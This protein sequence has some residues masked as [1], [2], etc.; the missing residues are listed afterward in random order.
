MERKNAEARFGLCLS[1]RKLTFANEGFF[2]YWNPTIR[3]FNR[4]S[5]E[6][7]DRNMADWVV[8]ESNG[9]DLCEPFAWSGDWKYFGYSVRCL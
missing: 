3:G 5:E 7:V 9:E 6:V 2:I 4:V 1:C 8:V